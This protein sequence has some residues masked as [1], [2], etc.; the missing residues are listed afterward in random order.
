M[1][2]RAQIFLVAAAMVFA[3]AV[4]VDTT[5][6]AFFFDP[7]AKESYFP[8]K[9]AGAGESETE[10]RHIAIPAIR[11]NTQVVSLGN[12]SPERIMPPARYDEVGWYR[13]GTVPG[14]RGTALLYGHLD[15]GL[16]LSGVFAHLHKLREG[17]EVYVVSGRGEEL[18]FV[19]EKSETYHYQEVPASVLSSNS[20]IPR[21]VL[22]TCAGKWV[23]DRLEGMTYDKRLLVEAVLTQNE[24]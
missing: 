3:G 7:Q 20:D 22:V 12:I 19:V 21:I 4:F 5:A 14:E 15:N 23:Y 10:P 1:S 2:R 6:R 8:G 16:G 24:R 11:V 9:S 18:R 13:H 17:D